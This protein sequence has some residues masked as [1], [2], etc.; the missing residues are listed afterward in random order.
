MS[1]K[2]SFSIHKI[3][4]KLFIDPSVHSS[5]KFGLKVFRNEKPVAK[6]HSD[7]RCLCAG[8]LT[9]FFATVSLSL[10]MLQIIYYDELSF[11][12][13][14]GKM[15]YSTFIYKACE[16]VTRFTFPPFYLFFMLYANYRFSIEGEVSDNNSEEVGFYARLRERDKG[17]ETNHRIG[18][19]IF[20]LLFVY[21][22]LFSNTVLPE[23]NDLLFS[24]LLNASDGVLV[25]LYHNFFAIFM[26][27]LCAFT[28]FLLSYGALLTSKI[29]VK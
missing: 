28:I 2:S 3:Q 13:S 16:V 22:L 4:E 9:V 24:P 11:F 27:T 23:L 25:I 12:V 7:F 21:C 6:V 26:A 5:W 10:V 20:P 15:F 19:Y 18:R 1:Y 14:E 29:K 17:L 8:F